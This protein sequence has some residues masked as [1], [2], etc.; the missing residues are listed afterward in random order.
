MTKSPIDTVTKY[1]KNILSDSN[2]PK[3]L[4]FIPIAIIL[5]FMIPTFVLYIA[6]ILLCAIIWY[7]IDISTKVINMF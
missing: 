1:F 7:K 6:I 5:Y 2:I 3:H 4:L